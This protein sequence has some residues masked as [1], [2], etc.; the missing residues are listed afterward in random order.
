MPCLASLRVMERPFAFSEHLKAVRIVLELLRR[1][2]LNLCWC[3]ADRGRVAL[4]TDVVRMRSETS[5]SAT[6]VNWQLLHNTH[7]VMFSHHLY[8]GHEV[9]QSVPS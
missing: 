5:L 3:V 2:P 6:S 8:K 9:Y 1:L 4:A 7:T